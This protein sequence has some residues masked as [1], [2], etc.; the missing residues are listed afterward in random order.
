MKRVTPMI[1]S[2]MT[3]IFAM[4]FFLTLSAAIFTTPEVYHA[5]FMRYQPHVEL[6]ERMEEIAKKDGVSAVDVL[7]ILQSKELFGLYADIKTDYLQVKLMRK[8][9]EMDENKIHTQAYEISQ[10]FFENPSDELVDDILI[11]SGINAL[12]FSNENQEVWALFGVLSHPL[13]AITAFVAYSLS[14]LIL[15]L[16]LRGERGFIEM[17]VSLLRA[18][19]F[20][21]A[22][23]FT[24]IS[25]SRDAYCCLF[26]IMII[27]S[28][29]HAP[30]GAFFG[31][32]LPK[33]IP[34][35]ALESA[36][37]KER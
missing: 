32:F 23:G 12:T 36:G 4:V 27:I 13:S 24:P 35:N 22:L 6:T 33:L 18:C 7:A 29:L 31:Y 34:A 14:S 10:K 11:L 9:L 2:V 30:V 20:T 17:G 1:I 28:T 8:N 26:V 19:A 25:S 15:Y 37:R 3:T 16:I 21:F 5:S